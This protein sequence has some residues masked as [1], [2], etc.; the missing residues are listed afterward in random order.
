VYTPGGYTTAQQAPLIVMLHGCGGNPTDFSNTT[1]MNVLADSNQ[2][3]VVY[4]AESANGQC[5]QWASTANQSRGSGEPAI[6]A[7][8]T[9]TVMGD[10]ARWKID[11]SRVYV[12]GF[13][14]GAGMAVVMAATYPDLYAAMGE[15]AG[16]EYKAS[17]SGGAPILGNGGP[18]PVTQGRLAYDGMGTLAR[19]VPVIAF[20]GTSDTTV[21]PINGEQVVRQWMETDRLASNGSYT[22][23]FTAPSG[24]TTGRAPGTNG[25][26]YTVRAWNDFAGN[27]V[28][29]YWTVT[30]M[31]HAWSGGSTT[32][33]YADPNGPSASQNMYAFFMAHPLGAPPPLQLTSVAA[34]SIGA[35]SAVITWRTNLAADSRVDDGTT[36]AYGNTVSDPALLTNHSLTIS[37]LASG[38]L[39]HYQVTSL[40]SVGETASSADVTFT[41]TAASSYDLLVSGSANRAGGSA[42]RGTT[43]S[44]AVYVFVSPA[45]GVTRVRFWLDNPQ[46]TATPRQTEGAGPWDFAGTAAN[47]NGNPF[48]TTT[49]ANGSHTIT[50]AIDKSAG[51]TDVVNATFTVTNGAPPPPPPS[52]FSLQVSSAADR[53][54]SSPLH[55][56]T[57]NGV[58]YVF[59]SPATGITRVRFWLDNPQMTGTPRQTEGVTPWDFAGTA[60]NGTANS[61]GT[62]TVANG[63]HAITVAIDKSGGGTD[64]VTATFT[65]TN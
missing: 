22:A 45:T 7:G 10:T 61:F 18:D 54:A 5:W 24:T 13:S 36:T 64:V 46:M 14:A 15:D 40:D 59:V 43:V 44:S 34:G 16:V 30:G 12:A 62:T 56:K 47:G 11:P 57:V 27:E 25:R 35:T 55:A 50:A 21:P 4:P 41:T 49:I 32:G 20:A 38:T 37:G 9:Q 26:A 17:T 65:I 60:A 2:F 52:T 33:A 42:L 58:I 19:V 39:Y 48:N 63:S 31:G 8:I 28:E 29:E 6:L 1:Q 23:S 3:I 53:S 51:G